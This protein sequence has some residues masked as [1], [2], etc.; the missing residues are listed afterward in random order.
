MKN[1][2]KISFLLLVAIVAL[3]GLLVTSCKKEATETNMIVRRWTL[4]SKTIVGVSVATDCEKL[5]VWNFKSDGTYAIY[6]SCDKTLTGTWS[7]AADAKTLT[8]D[9]STAY[10]V[11]ESTITKL[12]IDLQVGSTGLTRWSFN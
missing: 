1:M 2:K 5:S 8:L 12:V 10:A 11:I 7:L 6:D 3:S 4:A 9:G